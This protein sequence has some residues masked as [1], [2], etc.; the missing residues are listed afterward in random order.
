MFQGASQ[1]AVPFG[2]MHEHLCVHWCTCYRPLLHAGDKV[3]VVFKI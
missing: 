2:S 3:C 1:S